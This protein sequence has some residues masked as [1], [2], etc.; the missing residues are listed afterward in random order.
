[1][2]DHFSP[3][4]SRHA[5]PP[6]AHKCI[7]PNDPY[8]DKLSQL[9]SYVLINVQSIIPVQQPTLPPSGLTTDFP[10]ITPSTT[11][12]RYPTQSTSNKTSW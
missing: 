10:M 9:P 6:D 5:I 4:R 12:I 1:M 8:S 11:P 2:T 3:I 7:G